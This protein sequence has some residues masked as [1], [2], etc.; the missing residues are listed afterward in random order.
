[1]TG[2]LINLLKSFEEKEWSELGSFVINHQKKAKKSGNELFLLFQY[3]NN[4]FPTFSH[5]KFNKEQAYQAIFNNQQEIKGKLD[6]LMSEFLRVVQT[7]ILKFNNEGLGKLQPEWLVL[8]QYY[9]SR[10]LPKFFES[11]LKT[12]EKKLKTRPIL[13]F[14]F[15]WQSFLIEKEKVEFNSQ[16]R[17]KSSDLSLPEMLGSLDLFY[18]ITKLENACWL[19]SRKIHQSIEPSESLLF[20]DHVVEILPR[21]K[22]FE[23][24]PIQ[25]YYSAYYLLRNHEKAQL[26]DFVSLKSVLNDFGNLIPEQNLKS[27][28][29]ILRIYA[30]GKYNRGDDDYLSEAFKMYKAHLELGYLFYQGR[31]HPETLINVV[32]L[33]L[34][35]KE[36]DWVF[37]FLD[38]HKRKIAGA[39]DPQEIFD[40]NL[41]IYYFHCGNYEK[42]ESLLKDNYQHFGYKVAARRLEIKL[43]FEQDSVLLDSKIEAFKVFIHRLS[44]KQMPEKPK[45]LNNHFID[46]LRQIRNPKTLKNLDRIEKIKSRIHEKQI[47]AEREWLLEKLDEM[48]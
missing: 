46:F 31:I 13:G 5:P 21:T 28:Q 29:T 45:Q 11:N 35:M 17:P 42:S 32:T 43:L 20:L 23:E 25:I 16:F 3:F 24:A 47:V 9:R 41:A 15:Y 8:S 30:V 19:L 10:H 33:G 40:F 14:E 18:L 6:K 34:R 2:K 44:K 36:T 4:Y 22:F 12:A 48:K 39:T 27:L 7:F 37:Q 26:A 38:N 1:M